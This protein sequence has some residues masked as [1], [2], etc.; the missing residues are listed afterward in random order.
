AH[1]GYTDVRY[2]PDGNVPPDFLVNGRIAVEARVL[3]QHHVSNGRAQGLAIAEIPLRQRVENLLKSYG[4]PAQEGHGLLVSGL[5]GPWRSGIRW[6][7]RCVLIIR[8]FQ[9]SL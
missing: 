6:T 9:V 3:N 4:P 8:M 2:E 7:Y 5:A 1:R